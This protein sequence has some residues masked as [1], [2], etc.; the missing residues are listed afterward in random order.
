MALV[1]LD[2]ARW[3][4]ESNCFACE[5]ANGGGLRIPFLHDEEASTVVAEFTLDD[6]FSGA[7]SYVHGGVSLTILDE[8][9]AWATIAIAGRF[10]LTKRS[11]AE[12]VHP[13]RVGRRY[14][15]TA[16][17]DDAAGREL[18]TSATIVDHLDRPCVRGEATFVA[19]DAQE[20]GDAVGTELGEGEAGYVR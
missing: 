10:A 12:F 4:F 17:L 11:S 7:P 19:M 14:R 1:P 20:A 2:N 16:T 15:V 13:V 6:T 9:M 5:Q 8:A 3:G 18:R